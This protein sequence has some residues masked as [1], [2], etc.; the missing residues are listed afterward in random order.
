MSAS[1]TPKRPRGRPPGTGR[2]TPAKK[3]NGRPP[4]TYQAIAFVDGPGPKSRYIVLGPPQRLSPGTWQDEVDGKIP[5]LRGFVVATMLGVL[6]PRPGMPPLSDRLPFAASIAGRRAGLSTRRARDYYRE[7]I[8]AGGL[9]PA[10]YARREL[11]H[12]LDIDP[13][14]ESEVDQ[15]RIDLLSTLSVPIAATLTK[16]P[17]EK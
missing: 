4:R 5:S 1:T 15:R 10:A 16:N 14:P 6:M 12:L 3:A 9:E 13:L 8:A 2:P 11:G 17:R 7:Y